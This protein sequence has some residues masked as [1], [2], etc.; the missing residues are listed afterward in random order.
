MPSFESSLPDLQTSG[1]ILQVFIGPSRE[2]IVAYGTEA[3][4][5]PIPVSALVDTGA[6]ATVIT[7]ETAALLGLRSVGA[8]SI[9]TPTTIDPVLCR[10]FHVNV[11]FSPVFAVENIVVIEAPLTGQFF[12]CLI[13]RDVLSRGVLTYD[14]ARNRFSITF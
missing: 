12:Q 5:S 6:A 7:A 14:G 10:Q 13:G 4:A 11:H 1:P 9:H 3:V 8:V 2:L